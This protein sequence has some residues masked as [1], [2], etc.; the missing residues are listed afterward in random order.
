MTAIWISDLSERGSGH[1]FF[2]RLEV[3][4][5]VSLPGALL[6]N[7]SDPLPAVVDTVIIF[8]V[9]RIDPLKSMYFPTLAIGTVVDTNLLVSHTY[10]LKAFT[11]A[12]AVIRREYY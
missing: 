10:H 2:I 8:S 9:L 12:R 6:Q 4:S 11:R 3:A 7:D 1:H 5:T